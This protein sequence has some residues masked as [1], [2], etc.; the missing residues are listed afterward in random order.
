MK[1]GIF[2]ILLLFMS[3]CLNNSKNSN[4]SAGSNQTQ[5]ISIPNIN[6]K[7]IKEIIL[8][9]SNKR[10]NLDT[11]TS[12]KLEVIDKDGKKK[13]NFKQ[14]RM[15]NKTERCCRDKKRRNNSKKKD[16][17]VTIK[18]KVGNITS[19]EVKLE[20]YWEVNGHMFPPE[21]DSKINN[22]TLLGVDVNHN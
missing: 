9:I 6:P 2:L 7:N 1:N 13:Y 3:G 16:T 11:N 4:T 18:A 12:Y 19:N 8:S 5:N 17:N 14:C 15:E 21:L 10:L 22:S 20:I